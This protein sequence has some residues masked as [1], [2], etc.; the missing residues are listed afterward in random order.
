MLKSQLS[1]AE[2]KFNTLMLF[3][4]QVGGPAPRKLQGSIKIPSADVRTEVSLTKGTAQRYGLADQTSLLLLKGS[5]PALPCQPSDPRPPRFTSDMLHM[6][7]GT[8]NLAQGRE[9]DK[10]AGRQGE[11][12]M[13]P[14][15]FSLPPQP[16]AWLL[17]LVTLYHGIPLAANI[18]S[19]QQLN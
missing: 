1:C 13:T 14:S 16:L 12:N 9:P 6:V 10:V 15:Y 17:S 19:K 2:A 5:L 3:L 7:W 18:D 8:P 11:G 4:W